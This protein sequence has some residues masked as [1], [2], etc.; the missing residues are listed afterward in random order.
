MSALGFEAHAIAALDC[1]WSDLEVAILKI[2]EHREAAVAQARQAIEK[3]AASQ[4]LVDE[5]R[6]LQYRN[7]RH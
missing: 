1:S 5:C 4:R 6:Y 7:Y 3:H 2:I